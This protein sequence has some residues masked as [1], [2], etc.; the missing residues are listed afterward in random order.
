MHYIVDSDKSFH[1]A[2]VDLEAV[3]PRL[4]F[5]ILQVHDLGDALRRKGIDLDED[6]RV[7]EICNFRQTARLLSMAMRLN[8]A[9]PWRISVFTE[10]GVT[11]SVCSG[12]RRCWLR[13]PRMPGCR[14]WPGRSTKK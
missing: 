1:E 5:V 7:F 12:R 9:L 2:T 8:L 13:S 3:V 4:G 10:N 6:C 11:G 14:S